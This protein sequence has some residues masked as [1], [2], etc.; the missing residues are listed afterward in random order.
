M[1]AENSWANPPSFITINHRK[2]C[3]L[4]KETTSS[5]KSALELFYEGKP[6]SLQKGDFLFYYPQY[7]KIE[8]HRPYDKTYNKNKTKYHLLKMVIRGPE[9]MVLD[10]LI[11]PENSCNV[12]MRTSWVITVFMGCSLEEISS[13]AE[14]H[15]F[16]LI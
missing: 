15:I 3:V 4:K 2:R 16:R 5:W 14:V 6:T 12:F 10:G 11:L 7:Q 9:N 8:I 1:K 13:S